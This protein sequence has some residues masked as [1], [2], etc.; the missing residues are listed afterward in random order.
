MGSIAVPDVQ[1]KLALIT[2]RIPKDNVH[3]LDIIE[4]RLENGESLRTLW[5]KL[6]LSCMSIKS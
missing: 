6:K 1:A 5:G 2:R 4:K 3:Q